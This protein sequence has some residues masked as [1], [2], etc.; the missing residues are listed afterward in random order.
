MAQ[1]ANK[2]EAARAK[3]LERLV[4]EEFHDRTEDDTINSYIMPGLSTVHTSLDV[5]WL[6]NVQH[7]YYMF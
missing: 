6:M 3:Y 5:C 7:G 4:A 2:T 1:D